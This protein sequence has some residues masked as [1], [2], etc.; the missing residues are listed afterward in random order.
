M[1]YY[2]SNKKDSCCAETAPSPIED[3]LFLCCLVANNFTRQLRF[4][5]VVFAVV[6]S[7]D[8]MFT[9]RCEIPAQNF[10]LFK[11][12]GNTKYNHDK[13]SE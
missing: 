13:A 4:V 6:F 10:I 7:G 3:H 1:Q 8:F 9:F 12:L 5:V 2:V 11:K